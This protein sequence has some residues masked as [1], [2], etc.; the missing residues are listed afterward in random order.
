MTSRS[1]SLCT[2]GNEGQD[3]VEGDKTMKVKKA[4][5]E[6]HRM[7]LKMKKDISIKG[8]WEHPTVLSEGM[9]RCMKDIF[10]TLADATVHSKSLFSG[11][12]QRP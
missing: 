5:T 12:L 2:L 1:L 8:L 7:Y 3:D 4:S 6:A 10:I 11:G 9:V